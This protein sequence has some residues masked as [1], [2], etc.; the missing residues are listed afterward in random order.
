MWTSIKLI[1]CLALI[2]LVSISCNSPQKELPFL[3]YKLDNN[4][5]KTN[6]TITYGTHFKNQEGKIFTDENLKNKVFIAN[7]FFTR[8]PSICP[9]MKTQLT[10]IANYFS[11]TDDFIIVSHTIDPQ[12]D[13]PTILN[14][15]AKS[16]GVSKDKWFF[17]TGTTAITQQLA[18]Q[19][20]T[21]FKPNKEGTDFYHSSYAALVDKNKFI[22]GFYDL[23][24]PREVDLLKKDL[25]TLIF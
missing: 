6:Y 8:C 13:S 7:F 14:E 4:G 1:K 3:S 12:Y 25:K 5:N 16:T 10:N 18:E 21:N 9:P 19:Y 11:N 15:Y 24:I 2:V 20:K 17:L 22:R 23:A